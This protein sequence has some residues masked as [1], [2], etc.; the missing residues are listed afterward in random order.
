MK[1]VCVYFF[2]NDK[3]TIQG[4]KDKHI[5]LIFLDRIKRIAKKLLN[6]QFS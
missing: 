5:Q 3:E 2:L 4:R 6:P 1:A